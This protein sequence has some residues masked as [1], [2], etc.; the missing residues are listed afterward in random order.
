VWSLRERE[1]EAQTLVS[2]TISAS[3]CCSS[4]SFLSLSVFCLS[5]ED[6]AASR[7]PKFRVPKSYPR[8]QVPICRSKTQIPISALNFRSQNSSPQ[9]VGP[10]FH[11][12]INSSPQSVGSH[13]QIPKLKSPK[14]RSH[15]QI[16]KFRSPNVGHKL[17]SQNIGLE[18]R[19]QNFCLNFRS[20]ISGVNFISCF[21]FRYKMHPTQKPPPKLRSRFRI[22]NFRLC[23][24]GIPTRIPKFRSQSQFMCLGAIHSGPQIQVPISN[25]NIYQVSIFRSQNSGANFRSCLSTSTQ[26]TQIQVSKVRS[27]NPGSHHSGVKF[28]IITIQ[29]SN[30][31]FQ[32]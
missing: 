32:F 27:H 22:P 18:L 3:S 29:V 12:P 17:R 7:V 1:R 5:G 25:Q 31:R 9:S 2:D 6:D 21:L 20:Q 24:S 4:S 14:Y 23:F 11:I 15:F 30:F 16:P 19:S 8:N 26:G 13:F 10:H 28:Q